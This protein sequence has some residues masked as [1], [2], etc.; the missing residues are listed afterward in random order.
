MLKSILVRRVSRKSLTPAL[1]GL[2]IAAAACPSPGQTAG[3]GTITG[4]VTDTSGATIPNAT[5]VIT[6][7]DTAVSRTIQTN[8]DGSY[9]ATFLQ[10]GHY[11]VVLGGGAFGKFD[12]KDINLTVGRT[13]AINASLAAAAVSTEVI[14]NAAPPVLDTEKTEVSQTVGQQ[15]ISNLP[16]NGRRWDDFVLLTPNVVPDGG[17]GLVSFHGISGSLQPKLCRWCQQ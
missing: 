13:L 14:V 5:V 9:T 15:L 4:V 11:E 17:S 3:T 12:Q 10:P 1:A 16:V 7:T 2:L 6:N 8:S